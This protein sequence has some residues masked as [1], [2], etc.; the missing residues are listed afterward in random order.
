[1]AVILT[2]A[3]I[4]SLIASIAAL[5]ENVLFRRTS[6]RSHRNTFAFFVDFPI[7]AASQAESA[8]TC[9]TT[10]RTP[11]KTKKKR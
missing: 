8:S 1:M 4:A 6:V 2:K 11:D 7:R 3:R 10:N 9:I 5:F